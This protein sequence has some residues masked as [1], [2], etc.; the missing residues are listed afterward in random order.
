MHMA[1]KSLRASISDAL[2][3]FLSEYDIDTASDFLVDAVEEEIVPALSRYQKDG[4]NIDEVTGA[5][6]DSS[7]FA[8]R[9]ITNEEKTRYSDIMY[10]TLLAH[11][12]LASLHS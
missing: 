6:W 5:I 9:D 4:R 7:I 12:Q 11:G 10:A 8:L 3:I 2:C 1:M